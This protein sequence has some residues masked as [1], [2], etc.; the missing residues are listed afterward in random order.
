M[1][2]TS[3]RSL[4]FP[5]FRQQAFGALITLLIFGKDLNLYAFVGI[6]MLVGIV[7][8]NAIMMID[9]ALEAQRKEG[10]SPLDA[11]FEGAL[12][13]FRPIMMT[14]H[15]GA[16]GHT[17]DSHRIRSRRGITPFSRA[18]GCRRPARFP[19]PDTVYHPCCVL[20]YGQGPAD[21]SA[22]L[23]C[24][25]EPQK[26]IGVQVQEEFGYNTKLEH[27]QKGEAMK[28]QKFTTEGTEKKNVRFFKSSVNSVLTSSLSELCGELLTIR[29]SFGGLY[30]MKRLCFFLAVLIIVFPVVVRAE[31]AIQKEEVLTLEQCV[32]IA[33]KRQPSITAAQGNVDVFYA[34]KGQAE[35]GYYPQVNASLGYFGTGAGF[36]SSSNQPTSTTSGTGGAPVSSSSEETSWQ[37]SADA[38]A[39]QMIFDFWKTR[40]PGEYPA[41][42]RRF[43]KGRPHEHCRSRSS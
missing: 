30:I 3:I 19:A 13:R 40:D 27:T 35:A 11:I 34:R 28:P 25:S 22:A 41:T 37:Y 36:G 18:C 16:Y 32:E 20:L 39:S 5:V 7:K 17:A 8:K 43:S 15:G 31:E 33:L 38:T 23:P 12:V 26:K 10:K 42:E 24:R 4:S 21:R 1:K 29:R 14:Y 9:F 6:I 2:V